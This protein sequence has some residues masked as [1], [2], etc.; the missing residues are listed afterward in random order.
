M[1]PITPIDYKLTEYFG[2]LFGGNGWGVVLFGVICLL[3]TILCSGLLGFEREYRGHSAGLRTHVL[4]AVG[5]CLIM[6]VSM[7]GFGGLNATGRDPARLAAQVVTGVGFLGAGTIIQNGSDVKGLTTATTIWSSMAIG[8]CAGSGN[9]TICAIATMLMLFVLISLRKFERFAS[10]RNP[11]VII[12]CDPN[13]PILK[14]VLQ[15]A[16]R[17][18]INV[19]DTESQLINFQGQQCI[20]VIIRISP[21]K[22]SSITDFIDEIKVQS[23]PVDIKVSTDF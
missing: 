17:F 12:V 23:K 2:N 15:V 13:Q 22:Q 3:L 19:K 6:Y 18:A 16:N 9:L 5:S 1:T 14:E 11:M 20:R 4:V 10:K 21:T 8:L 7:F